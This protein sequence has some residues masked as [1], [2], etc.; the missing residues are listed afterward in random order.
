MTACDAA[1]VD[2]GES[3]VPLTRF[4]GRDR[5]LDDLARL[6]GATRLLTLTGA[7]GSGK[8]RLAHEAVHRAA[9]R[10]ERVIWTDLAPLTDPTLLADRLAAALRVPE[11]TAASPLDAVVAAVG[12]TR[13]LLVL[14]NCEHLVDACAAAAET[15]LRGCPALVILATS[16]EA[17]GVGSETAWLVPPLAPA[18]AVQL[19]VDRA[20]AAASTFALTP[21]NAAAVEDVCR[22][23]DGI[24]LAIELAAARVRVLPPAQIARRLD[25]A[26]RLL[27]TGSR[28]ALPR[29][30]TLRATLDWSFSL[31]GPREQTLLRRLSVFAGGFTLEAAEAICGAT[32]AAGAEQLDDEVLDVLSSLIAK[33]LVAVEAGE[34]AVRY[35]LLETVRQYAG[36]RLAEAGET[37]AMRAAHAAYFL[38][39]AEAA[40]P[41]LFAGAAGPRWITEVQAEADNL[42]A[43]AEWAGEDQARAD[44]ALRLGFALHWFWWATGQ[45]GES[46]HRLEAAVALGGGDALH[47]GRALLAL[48]FTMSAQGDLAGVAPLMGEAAHLLLGRDEPRNVAYL[49]TCLSAGCLFA[50]DLAGACRFADEALAAVAAVPP[51]AIHSLVRYYGGR[52][53]EATGD[54]ARARTLFEEAVAVGRRLGHRPSIAHPLSMLGRLAL[55]AGDLDT[56]HAALAE[57]LEIHVETE[58]GWGTALAL[59]GLA[60]AALARGRHGRATRL[61]AAADAVR[62][63]IHVSLVPAEHAARERRLAAARAAL[64]GDFDRAYAEGQALSLAEIVRAALGE[65]AWQ[66]QEHRVVDVAP[67]AAAPPAAPA[68]ARGRLR[69]AAL[70]PL[71]VWVDGR[72]VETAAWSSARPRELLVYLLVHPEGRTKEQVGLA[73]WPD[74][75]GA[76]LRNNFHVTMHRLRRALGGADWVTLVG[77]R[78]AIDP[79]LLDEFDAAAFEREVRAARQAL[80]GGDAGAA[81]RLE[82]ALARYGG[83]LL[84]GE[85]VGDWHIEHR[86]R[87]QRLYVDG[88]MLLGGTQAA[89]GRHAEAA[90]AFRRVLARD[91]LHEDALRGLVAAHAALGERAEA[92]RVYQ[93]FAERMRRELGAEP[94]RANRRARDAPRR[95]RGALRRRRAR[96][97][98]ARRARRQAVAASGAGRGAGA[99]RA[100]ARCVRMNAAT[101]STACTASGMYGTSRC[102]PWATRSYTSSRLSP[103]AARMRAC[104]R[105]ASSRSISVAPTWRSTGGSPPA[106]P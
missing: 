41:H 96:R 67:P 35:H 21:D 63:R 75:A 66:T 6:L 55:G 90:D 15:L 59:E 18:D 106:S 2:A 13:V 98:P 58:D 78:Y 27:T 9:V 26:L 102:Q 87:L 25:D 86:D 62:A 4:I 47:R 68:D 52:A 42:R 10:F 94:A 76:Q 50:G 56:A 70:G 104:I 81:T 74:A 1:A 72:P 33:S 95:G 89:A 16:R 83:D 46:R 93:R 17:I 77:E 32:S 54:P 84:D 92:V 71:R 37:E 51:H 8:T 38:A 61:T 12:A 23:L 24:P 40:E 5:E 65:S 57:G 28:T 45:C 64:G 101:S 100:R 73:F 14:D 31:L 79:A 20:R 43:A 30:R 36:E 53:A 34:G 39:V 22:R 82:A 99:P 29:H 91:D 11:R 97:S 44:V 19:F 3:S 80:R 69:V 88:L 7:G 105:R 48:G 49:L 103:P 60:E 85:P